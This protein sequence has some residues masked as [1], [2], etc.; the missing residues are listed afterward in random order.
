M[1]YTLLAYSYEVGFYIQCAS[2]LTN[3]TN[4]RCY[5]TNSCRICLTNHM[6]LIDSISHHITP[7]D[8]NSLGADTHVHMSRKT[9]ISRNQVHAG[10]GP[11]HT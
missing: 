5:I 6:R 8:I 4:Y 7:P 9:S 10:H 2:L 3:N 11:T 1:A